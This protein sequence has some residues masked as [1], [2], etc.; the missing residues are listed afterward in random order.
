MRPPG[1]GAEPARADVPCALMF[2]GL[3]AV[4]PDQPGLC[5]RHCQADTG[6]PPLDS[7]DTVVEPQ[8]LPPLLFQLAAPQQPAAL[9]PAWRE[10]EHR[11]EH[12]PPEAHRLAHC[13]YRI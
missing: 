9:A 12:A 1:S 8:P 6:Q 2:S 5:F 13:C 7:A 11:R 3:M 4:D 10:R